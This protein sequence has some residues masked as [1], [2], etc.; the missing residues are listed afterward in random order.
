MAHG[1]SLLALIVLSAGKIIAI[2][3]LPYL[4]EQFFFTIYYKLNYTK[5][6]KLGGYFQIFI[7]FGLQYQIVRGHAVCAKL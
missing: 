5:S 4:I 3:L 1:S 6:K 7:M 2:S